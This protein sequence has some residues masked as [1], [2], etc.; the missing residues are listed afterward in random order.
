MASHG[1]RSTWWRT[2]TIGRPD[3]NTSSGPRSP[4]LRAL[5][6]ARDQTTAY[7]ELVEIEPN[8]LLMAYDRTPFGWQPVPV[9]SDERGRVF[10][11]PIDVERT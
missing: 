5:R 9:D 4:G 8:R 11:M 10:V 1:R 7:T 6:G 3:P 2:T